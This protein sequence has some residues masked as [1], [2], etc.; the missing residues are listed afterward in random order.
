MKF[1]EINKAFEQRAYKLNYKERCKIEHEINS[2]YGKYIAQE[3]C[4]HYSYGIN[5]RSYA[6]YFE[7]HGFNNYNI[8]SR[9]LVKSK[10]R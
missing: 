8:F 5:N 6:Y 10:R 7:N 3:F 2:N 1:W 4:I 9:K